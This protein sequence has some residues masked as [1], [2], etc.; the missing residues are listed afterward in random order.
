MEDYR[1][2]L[3]VYPQLITQ[4]A[5]PGSCALARQNL[6]IFAAV[7]GAAAVN[8]AVILG[9]RSDGDRSVLSCRSCSCRPGLNHFRMTPGSPPA[10][11]VERLVRIRGRVIPLGTAR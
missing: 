3:T 7:Q 4:E 8:L 11:R 5:L 2:E 1:A 10:M 9:A 6:E